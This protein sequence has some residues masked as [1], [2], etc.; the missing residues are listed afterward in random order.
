MQIGA[1]KA[2]L[3][4]RASMNINLNF[5][6]YYPILVKFEKKKPENSDV[7]NFQLP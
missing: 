6:I 4:L 1:M 2:S 3:Y 7:K 5:D